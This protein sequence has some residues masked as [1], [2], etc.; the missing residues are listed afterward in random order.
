MMRRGLQVR[1]AR[2]I[3]STFAAAIVLGAGACDRIGSD[4][5]GAPA[6][7]TSAPAPA[8]P[9]SVEAAVRND[10]QVRRPAIG[11][12]EPAATVTVRPQVSGE[13]QKIHF[14]EGQD[15]ASGQL[16]FS[17]DARPF[18]SSLRLS[19]ASLERDQAVAADARREAKR[20][21]ELFESQRA[22]D[23]ERDQAVFNADA[24][25][26]QVKADAA[27]VDRAKLDLEYCSIRSPV[28]GRAGAF[29]VHAGNVVKANETD[30]VVLNQISPV[31]V[32]V[33]VPERYLPEITRTGGEAARMELNLE[34][35]AS[36]RMTAPLTFIDNTVDRNTGMVRV[37]ASFDN[38]DRSLWPG[39]FVR[40]WLITRTI[41]GAVLVPSVSVQ[42]GQQ[43][44]FVFVVGED[45][46][47]QMRGV[48]VGAVQDQRTV[49]TAGLSDGDIVVT[50]GQ[51]RLTPGAKV[52]PKTSSARTASAAPEEGSS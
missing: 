10:V 45:R 52:E 14:V 41:R 11:W 44:P 18:E 2:T 39:R 12:V 26:A 20:V 7:A 43:G 35:G 8:V 27:E 28:N 31:D 5:G 3:G 17:L 47:V 51:L 34:D 4:G 46:T 16:L 23:R 13:L 33:S 37:K 6:A 22:S 19:E 24:K 48:T 30:L 32:T 50:D 29:L 38:T 25:E 9:V 21:S 15:V 40:A 42:T 36:A 49:I 1:G